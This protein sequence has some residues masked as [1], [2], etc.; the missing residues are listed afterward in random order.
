M[1]DDSTCEVSYRLSEPQAVAIVAALK[2]LDAEQ[3]DELCEETKSN[4][5]IAYHRLN[6]AL[7]RSLH[8]PQA[9]HSWL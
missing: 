3:V 5:S 6:G 1:S 2:L 4:L 7:T 8:G 9:H